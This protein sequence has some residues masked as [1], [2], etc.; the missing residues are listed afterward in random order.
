MKSAGRHHASCST[1]LLFCFFSG[2]LRIN[3]ERGYHSLPNKQ[4]PS[5]TY[6]NIHTKRFTLGEDIMDLRQ[7]LAD[8]IF[9]D[10]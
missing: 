1:S 7:A 3:K 9:R 5:L 10:I 4:T 2:Q 6:K 8:K